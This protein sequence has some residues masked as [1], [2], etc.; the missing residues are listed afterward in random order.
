MPDR[1]VHLSQSYCIVILESTASINRGYSR[2]S[3]NTVP[4]KNVMKK[5]DVSCMT[6]HFP[7]RETHIQ[8][9]TSHCISPALIH[10]D[11]WTNAR[12]QLQLLR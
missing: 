7:L 11:L 10:I 3:V 9:L 1:C 4:I 5:L 8:T 2:Q 12:T 6:L